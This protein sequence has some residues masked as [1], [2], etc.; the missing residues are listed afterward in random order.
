MTKRRAEDGPDD[1][2]SDGQSDGQSDAP[3]GGRSCGRKR[4]PD[5]VLGLAADGAV[6]ALNETAADL[7]AA[8]ESGGAPELATA[9][10][11][12]RGERG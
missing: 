4:P 9:L 2:R 10:E 8:V 12:L 1:G 7:M 3:A 5:A 6:R 11:R